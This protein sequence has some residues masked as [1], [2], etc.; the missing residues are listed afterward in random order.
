MTS[1]LSYSRARI[2]AERLVI[3]AGLALVMVAVALAMVLTH[4]SMAGIT[5]G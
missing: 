2:R 1:R 4:P 3:G 5:S